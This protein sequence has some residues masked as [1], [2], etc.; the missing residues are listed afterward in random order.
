MLSAVPFNF[1]LLIPSL[2]ICL[3]HLLSTLCVL[4][5]VALFIA[6]FCLRS[7]VVPSKL[8]KFVQRAII[9]GVFLPSTACGMVL[10]AQK[11]K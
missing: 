11:V 7:G 10:V 6:G 2:C 3:P 5:L 1:T 9:S 8:V 4:T